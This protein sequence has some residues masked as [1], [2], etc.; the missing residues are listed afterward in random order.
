MG[1]KIDIDLVYGRLESKAYACWN[2]K[3]TAENEKPL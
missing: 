1:G 2:V 3:F